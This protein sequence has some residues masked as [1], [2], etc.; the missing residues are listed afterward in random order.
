[1][2]MHV[3]AKL[4]TANGMDVSICQDCNSLMENIGLLERGTPVRL[5]SLRRAIMTSM[6]LSLT[7]NPTEQTL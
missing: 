7:L 4:K 1:M 3:G 2:G 6:S 5:E